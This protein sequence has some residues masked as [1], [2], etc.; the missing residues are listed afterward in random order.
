MAQQVRQGEGHDDR[1]A[2]SLVNAFAQSA[3]RLVQTEQRVRRGATQ[4]KN[5]ARP[6]AG[7]RIVEI[8]SLTLADRQVAA[9]A[10][11]T[12]ASAKSTS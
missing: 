10:V 2:A 12:P 7:D 6:D 11:P 4:G 9:S 3:E 5:A 1:H 8:D